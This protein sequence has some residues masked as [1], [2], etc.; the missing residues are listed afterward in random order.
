[1]VLSVR[2]AGARREERADAEGSVSKYWAGCDQPSARVPELGPASPDQRPADVKVLSWNLW[3]EPDDDGGSAGKI[4]LEAGVLRTYDVMGFQECESG[5]RLLLDAGLSAEAEIM[6]GGNGLCMAFRYATFRLLDQGL[7]DVAEDVLPRPFGRR[8]VQWMR[9]LHLSSNRTVLFLNHHG[10]LPINT[11]GLCGGASVAHGI[12]DVIH[13]NH[14]P[15]DGIILV[16]DFNAQAGSETIRE[17]QTRLRVAMDGAAFHGTDH[18]FTNLAGARGGA[19]HILG[20]DGLYH[21]PIRTVISF[22]PPPPPNAT[23]ATA[24]KTAAGATKNGTAASA[25]PRPSGPS[26]AGQNLPDVAARAQ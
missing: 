2:A 21:Y 25:A 26:A 10:P 13:E 20:N 14:R 15:G 6:T 23:N 24:T 1:V 11:G 4:A 3:Q 19:R 18:I 22:H 17:L 12:L 9:L 8:S 7:E 5:A 16:G